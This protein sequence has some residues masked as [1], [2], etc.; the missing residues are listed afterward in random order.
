[1]SIGAQEIMTPP[2]SLSTDNLSIDSLGID[3]LV[4]IDSIE[5]AQD[6]LIPIVPF[7]K[8]WDENELS[9]IEMRALDWSL[10]WLDTTDCIRAR[11]CVHIKV[12]KT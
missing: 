7:Y 5:M 4:M 2:D 8:L 10:R 11:T 9:D 3:S 6:T 1:M 12:R